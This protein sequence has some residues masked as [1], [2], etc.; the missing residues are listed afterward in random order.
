M[1]DLCGDMALWFDHQLVRIHSVAESSAP[2]PGV[3]CD[4]ASKELRCCPTSHSALKCIQMRGCRGN[5]GQTFTCNGLSCSFLEL[6]TSKLEWTGQPSAA[7]PGDV[8]RSDPVFSQLV[9]NRATSAGS[10]VSLF[11]P[12]LQ[13]YLFRITN[14][15]IIVA[16]FVG[17]IRMCSYY[18]LW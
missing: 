2:P 17:S 4:K 3:G 5:S 18:S 13:M 10:T 12:F 6:V 14:G 9:P 1:R 16:F 7:T 15:S 8:R 11:F